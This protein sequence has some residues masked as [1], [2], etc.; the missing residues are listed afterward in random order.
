MIDVGYMGNTREQLKVLI[1][2]RPLRTLTQGTPGFGK[3]FLV[4]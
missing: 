2:V 1:S 4:A 3:G